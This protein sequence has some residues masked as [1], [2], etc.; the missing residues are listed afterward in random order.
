[1]VKIYWSS[2]S[3]ISWALEKLVHASV[4]RPY[5]ITYCS[6]V[7]NPNSVSTFCF[8]KSVLRNLFI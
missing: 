4:D 3:D 5:D 2:I 7:L 1:M 8:Y 6:V